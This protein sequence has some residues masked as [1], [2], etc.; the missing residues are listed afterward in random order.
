MTAFAL[1]LILGVAAGWIASN[2]AP[3]RARAYLRFAAVLYAA[4]ALSAVFNLSPPAVTDIVATL[5]SAILCV[6]AFAAFRRS[7]PVF[8]TSA[9]LALAALAG[10]AAAATGIA[11]LAAVPQVLSALLMA[12]IA[13]R[14]GRERASLYLVLAALSLLGSAACQLVP[15]MAARAGL[16]LFSAAGLIG[17]AVASDVLVEQRQKDKHRLAIRRAR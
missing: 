5:A 10:I 11:V 6:A 15:G 9:L 7:P 14:Q 8:T 16:M 12:L 2:G 4:L 1:V 17:V 3:P 13:R